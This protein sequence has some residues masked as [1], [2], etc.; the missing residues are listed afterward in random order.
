M[1]EYQVEC[2]NLWKIYGAQ[3]QAATKAVRAEELTKTEVRDRFGC[4]VGVRDASFS[5]KRGEIF[6]IMGL[7]GSGKSTVI[8]H[9][10][11]LIEPTSGEVYVSG[12]RVDTMDEQALRNLRSETMGMVFQHM[13]LWPHRNLADNVA[14]GLECR[15]VPRK[16]RLEAAE[17][18]LASM[19]LQG[20][21]NHYPDQ[22]SGGMQ[23]RVGIARAL[24]ADPAIL[25]MDEPFSALDP[26]IRRQLQ[27][28][29]LELSSQ[30]QKTTIFV[31]HDL[32]E[33]TRMGH[34]MAIMNDG[35]IVQI[36]TPE[37]VVLNPAD[38]YVREFVKGISKANLVRARTIMSAMVAPYVSERSVAENCELG[39]LLDEFVEDQSPVT[40][41]DGAG[42]PV[43]QIT[44][45]AA[46]KALRG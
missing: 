22:L 4:V 21:S 14:Y 7:S 2:R 19:G 39:A 20:W 24:A 15:S 33:A 12:R 13:A 3:V 42:N 45:N 17:R 44:I 11:R 6:C 8:R 30:L 23:Q 10:N 40:V 38:D 27:D 32:D 35:V 16:A 9:I 36:G 1:T 25:L 41:I 18:A 37:E 34:R 43:G 46:L 5:I 29:F 28:Q 26:L 31:T